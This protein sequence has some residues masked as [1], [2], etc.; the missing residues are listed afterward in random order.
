MTNFM[1]K[2]FNGMRIKGTAKHPTAANS[3]ILKDMPENVLYGEDT[4]AVPY[5]ELA[6]QLEDDIE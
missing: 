2:L 4:G 5:D 3:P 1:S 6:N